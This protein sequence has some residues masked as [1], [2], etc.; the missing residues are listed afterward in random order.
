MSESEKFEAQGRAY[1]RA[2][3]LRSEIAA[4][5]AEV[6]RHGKALADLARRT[7]ALVS[8][9]LREETGQMPEAFKVVRAMRFEGKDSLGTMATLVEELHAK[10]EELSKLEE[11][12]KEF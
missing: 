6:S 9:P 11:R 1:A 5:K 7:E 12:V 10:A 2:K 3:E 4:V 8:D